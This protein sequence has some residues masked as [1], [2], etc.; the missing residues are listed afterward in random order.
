M[1]FNN[2]LYS[3]TLV[4]VALAMIFWL[5]QKIIHMYNKEFF[6]QLTFFVSIFSLI[7][8]KLAHIL[9]HS[10]YYSINPDEVFSG[11]GFSILGAIL[12]GIITIFFMSIIYKANFNHLSDK[13]FLALPLA[14]GF[15]RLANI[16]NEELMPYAGYEMIFSFFNFGI[17]YIIYKYIKRDGLI[18]A[19]YF[20]N[21]GIFRL[22]IEYAK[23]DLLKILSLISFVF[24][25]YGIS[26]LIKVVFKL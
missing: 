21:Y 13:I 15:G 3:V 1:T 8:A 11:N 23:D 4:L 5:R 18:T 19:I 6:W 17:L 10:Y 12:F 24:V 22:I 2:N 25:I 20:L 16:V 7:G 9:Q 26:K 14:Q